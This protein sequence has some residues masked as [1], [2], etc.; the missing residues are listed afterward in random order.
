LKIKKLARSDPEERPS[1][2][3]FGSGEKPVFSKVKR[4]QIYDML[5][6]RVE[7]ILRSRNEFREDALESAWG[8][9]VESWL[10]SR[11]YIKV[12]I[13]KKCHPIFPLF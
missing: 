11:G 12:H 9:A 7:R 13:N 4:R 6:E 2:V 5:M 10:Q 3:F 1:Q 8:I